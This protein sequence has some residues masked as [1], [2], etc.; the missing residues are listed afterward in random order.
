[1]SASTTPGGVPAASAQEAGAAALIAWPALALMMV[2]SV[3]SI[4]Q[5]SDS[6]TPTVSPGATPA[7][8]VADTSCS[9]RDF[10]SADVVEPHAARTA[11]NPTTAAIRPAPLPLPVTVEL[12]TFLPWPGITQSV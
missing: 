9:A 1:M 6:A 2:A 12:W 4:A 11:T 10:S 3:G 7:A 5:L 8:W